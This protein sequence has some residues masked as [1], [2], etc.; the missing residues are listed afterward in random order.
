M[1]VRVQNE[2]EAGI[3]EL[4]AELCRGISSTRSFTESHD[5]NDDDK[6]IKAV[7]LVYPTYSP[8]RT[9]WILKK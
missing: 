2:L 4:R 1:Y 5:K 3:A 7:R 6:A 8:R 9:L